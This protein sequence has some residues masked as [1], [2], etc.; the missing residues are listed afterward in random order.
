MDDA[1]TSEIVPLLLPQDAPSFFFTRSKTACQT[2][3]GD[4]LRAAGA[5]CV[6]S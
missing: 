4:Q 3:G 5:P 6:V 2:E 1:K